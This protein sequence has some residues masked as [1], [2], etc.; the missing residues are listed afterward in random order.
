MI[1][2]KAFAQNWVDQQQTTLSDWHQ[3]IW[4]YAEP[5]FREYKS[6]AWY[7][8]L[9]RRQGFE[10]EEGSGGMPTAFCATFRNGD[11]PVLATYAEYDAVPGNNQAATTRRQPRE[12]LSRFAPGHTDPHSALGISA[13]GG[14]L[15]AKAAMLEHGLAGTLKFF[16][17]PAEKLRASKPVHAAKGYY[18]DLDAAISFHP[19]YMLP[20]NNTTTWDTHCGIAYAYIYTFTCDSPQDWIAADKYSPIPQNHLAARAPGANDALV[21]FYTLNESMRRST[22]P[23]TGLWSYNEAI[24]TAGQATADNLPPHIA[25]IQYL[26]RCDSLEQAE[27]ISQVMDNNAAA[28]AL[29]TGCQWNKTWVCKSRGGLPN[30]VLAQATYDNLQAIGA[31]TWDDEAIA[32]AQQIQ[33]NLGL[34]PMARP[35][36]PETETLIDPQ[37]CERLLRQQMPAWQKHLTSD[38]Y[39]EYTWHCPT[40][41]LLV[42][43]P[44]LSA[45]P[46]YTYP[47]WVP[48]ALGGIRQTIDPMIQVAAKT[49]GATLI[50]L[51]TRPELL[52][53]ARQEFTERTGGG[54][55]GTRWQAPLLPR[56]FKV[57]HDF[58]W[59]EYIR[60]AR[61]EEWWIP[62]RADE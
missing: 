42:A 49:I 57:P 4:H 34:E 21:H 14:L 32:I 24:L 30:H 9:L 39:P 18:D 54:I 53:A 56:D 46:G 8:E 5:A 1:E 12:G 36:L 55:G 31:P 10:V 41:R 48:N 47:D 27:A 2:P 29:A 25:Q 23:F 58:R 52:A 50:D 44:M 40:V 13:L 37:E 17:E 43:R 59:P 20:L 26:S 38:D 45:P 11:G 51:L 62:A 6:C 15:A 3:V 28:A 16:G 33:G 35:F 7:V 60:T 22:L 19:T 61:G